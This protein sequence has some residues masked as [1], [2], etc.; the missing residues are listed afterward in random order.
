MGFSESIIHGQKRH[1]SNILSVALLH[2]TSN[3]IMS[4]LRTV[5]VR[6]PMSSI[7]PP[8]LVLHV[9]GFEP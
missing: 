9:N 3:L 6:N 1:S 5:D 7:R 2:R 4:M 8:T